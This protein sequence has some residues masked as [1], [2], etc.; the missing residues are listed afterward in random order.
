MSLLALLIADPHG[1]AP[2]AEA[3]RAVAAGALQAREPAWQPA[4]LA[5]YDATEYEKLR[6]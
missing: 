6:S 5:E 3:G 1:H 2:A 4:I